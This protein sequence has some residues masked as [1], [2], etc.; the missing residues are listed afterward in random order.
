MAKPNLSEGALAAIFAAG[1]ENPKEAWK[2]PTLQVLL[3][4]KIEAVGNAPERY[5]IVLSDGLHFTQGMI[6]T[7]KIPRHPRS[8]IDETLTR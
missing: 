6:G 2:N 3:V 7:R 8:G 4:K 1:V 5:R